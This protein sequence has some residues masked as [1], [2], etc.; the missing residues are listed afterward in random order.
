MRIA[1]R[2]SSCSPLLAGA[3]VSTAGASA[4]TAGPVPPMATR[5]PAP[6]AVPTASANSQKQSTPAQSRAKFLRSIPRTSPRKVSGC[7]L[8][9]KRG[10]N[11]L[12]YGMKICYNRRVYKHFSWLTLSGRF[13]SSSPKGRAFDI[14][15]NFPMTVKTSHFGGGGI[16]QAMTERVSQF[17]VL[18]LSSITQ[19]AAPGYPETAF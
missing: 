5:S 3:A 2:H 4:C 16:A 11:A 12:F 17:I 19:N 9:K 14:I 13:A 18:I 7:I 1:A 15:G 6:C 10:V 8:C